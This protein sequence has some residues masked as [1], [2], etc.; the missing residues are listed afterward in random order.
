[1]QIVRGRWWLAAYR[2][3]C[4]EWKGMEAAIQQSLPR[5]PDNNKPPISSTGRDGTKSWR[6]QRTERTERFALALATGFV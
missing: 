2:S 5:C 1:M 4:K 6:K 3:P